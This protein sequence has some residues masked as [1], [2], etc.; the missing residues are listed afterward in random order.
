MRL[1]SGKII[2]VPELPIILYNTLQ[3]ELKDFK[4]LFEPYKE[5]IRDIM[6]IILTAKNFSARFPLQDKICDVVE[7][8]QGDHLAT[9]GKITW[10]LIGKDDVYDNNIEPIYHERIEKYLEDFTADLLGE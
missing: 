2:N 3:A 10:I 7:G 4:E 9:A 1:R 5:H 6:N 8:C